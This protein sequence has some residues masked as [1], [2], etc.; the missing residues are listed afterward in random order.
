M[1]DDTWTCSVCTYINDSSLITRCGMCDAPRP[2]QHGTATGAAPAQP[3]FRIPE[4]AVFQNVPQ[5][6]QVSNQAGGPSPGGVKR[7]SGGKV[8]SDDAGA[9]AGAGTSP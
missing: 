8:V 3:A 4:S 9:L 6:R 2:G 1:A 5:N 7:D